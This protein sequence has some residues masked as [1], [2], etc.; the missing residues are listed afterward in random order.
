MICTNK[1]N[2]MVD[3]DD[4]QSLFIGAAQLLMLLLATNIVQC[5]SIQEPSN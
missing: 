1:G 5:S 2:F 4:E 3:K